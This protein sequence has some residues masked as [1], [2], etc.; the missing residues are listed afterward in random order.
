MIVFYLSTNPNKVIAIMSLLNN[1][2]KH[3]SIIRKS[4]GN[5]D[6]NFWKVFGENWLTLRIISFKNRLNFK[7]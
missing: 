1:T 6:F 4:Y 7:K 3:P 5:F 2:I